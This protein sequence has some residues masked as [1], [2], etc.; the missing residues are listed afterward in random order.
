MN[1]HTL[2]FVAYYGAFYLTLG[3]FLPYFPV[4]LEG[5]GLSAEWIG[6]IGAAGLAGRMLVSPIGARWADRARFQREPVRVFAVLAFVAFALHVPTYSPW[7]FVVLA[8]FGSAAF[9]GQIPIMDAFAM[10]ESKADRLP[11]G[12]VRAFG[13]A[14]FILSNFGAGALLDISGPE[15]VILYVVTGTAFI[16][17]SAMG[18]PKGDEGPL[19]N[20]QEFDWVQFGRL[21]RGP[22]G[23][24]L[25]A[26]ACIQGSHGFYYFFSAIAWGEQGLSRTL[27]GALWATGVAIE[28]AFLWWSGRGLLGRLS[29]AQLLGIGAVGSIVRWALTALGPP[30]PVLFL[31]QL[32]HALTYA[33]TYIGFLRFAVD[34][35]PE[36]HT[37]TVQAA[38]AALSGGLVMAAASAASGYFYAQIGAGGF[39]VMIVPAFL[40]LVAAIAL[41]RVSAL[42]PR[43]NMH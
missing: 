15:S 18:L 7:L 8:F 37:A 42:P 36:R 5:R 20:S 39:A 16:A 10:R 32:F 25:L 14:A 38:N 28:I 11:F 17:L 6:W 24:A 23:W 13:S 19:G 41:H 27:I 4:W 40:G 31:L 26:S 43:E 1:T 9:F 12:P 35:M 33:A 22:F 3:A 29:P 34:G 30:L 21:V 2:R